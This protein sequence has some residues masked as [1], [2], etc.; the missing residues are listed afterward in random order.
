MAKKAKASQVTKTKKTDFNAN[1]KLYL[2]Q[3]DEKAR[4]LNQT[5]SEYFAQLRQLIDQRPSTYFTDDFVRAGR[6]FAIKVDA[7]QL[8]RCRILGY[9][10]IVP[11]DRFVARF[12]ITWVGVPIIVAGTDRTAIFSPEGGRLPTDWTVINEPK[13]YPNAKEIYLTVGITCANKSAIKDFNQDV[14]D[15]LF[16]ANPNKSGTSTMLFEVNGGNGI[17]FYLQFEGTFSIVLR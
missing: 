9:D 8:L 5:D 3:F 14:V 10:G 7:N 4:S 16:Y 1:K 6:Q 2:Q 13:K 15:P 12:A 17:G 11:Y